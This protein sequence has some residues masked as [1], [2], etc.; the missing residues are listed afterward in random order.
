MSNNCEL[1][2]KGRFP[3]LPPLGAKLAADIASFSEE[4]GQGD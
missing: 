1:P 3:M 4:V 2:C